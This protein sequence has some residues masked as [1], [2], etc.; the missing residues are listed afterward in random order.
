MK[1]LMI[2]ISTFFYS[3]YGFSYE[4]SLDQ[5]KEV[6]YDLS[7]YIDF[8]V[9]W[10][11]YKYNGE[12]FP[13]V[14]FLDHTLIQIYTYG[15]YVYAQAEFSGEKLPEAMAVYDRESKA[16]LI[17]ETIKEDEGKVEVALVH[18]F[19]HF[20]QDIN[21]YTESLGEENLICSESEAYDIQVLWQIIN[22]V[23][24]NLIAEYQQ[25][26]LLAA[27]RCMGSPFSSN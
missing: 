13:E 9:E 21:G 25:K 26:S 2:L 20:L 19:V 8:V 17:S 11:S 27:M 4:I 16:I 14:K 24:M 15:D 12:T 18:E 7:S 3:L 22:E 10:S 6:A 23:E 5:K 1:S